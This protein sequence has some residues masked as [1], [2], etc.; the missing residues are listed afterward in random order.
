MNEITIRLDTMNAEQLAALYHLS[1]RSL[2]S[3]DAKMAILNA[4]IANC[5]EL[6]FARY[7]NAE[8]EKAT[9]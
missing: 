9:K 7:V 5:G 3:Q 2:Q 6:E 1:E 8:R 4:G